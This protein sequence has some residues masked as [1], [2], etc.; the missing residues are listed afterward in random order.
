MLVCY[1]IL[2]YYKVNYE[3]KNK[4]VKS[5]KN[6]ASVDHR[7]YIQEALYTFNTILKTLRKKLQIKLFR[8]LR[9]NM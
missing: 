1:N 7:G 8:D 6:R 5:Y 4:K 2:K 3:W 9:V